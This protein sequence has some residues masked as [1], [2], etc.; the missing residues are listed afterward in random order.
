MSKH[1]FIPILGTTSGN[2]DYHRYFFVRSIIDRISQ[3]TGKRNMSFLIGE[4][5]F[6]CLIPQRTFRFLRTVG[7]SGI[8]SLQLQRECHTKLSE[9]TGDYS[10]VQFP[11]IFHQKSQDIQTDGIG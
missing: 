4:S 7:L 9:S 3:R 1:L 11:G 10:I 2:H 5:N 8:S 6:L